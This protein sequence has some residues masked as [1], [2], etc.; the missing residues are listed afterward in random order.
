MLRRLLPVLVLVFGGVTASTQNNDATL[1]SGSRR[2]QQLDFTVSPPVRDLP[3]QARSTEPPKDKPVRRPHAGRASND[4][5]DP[6]VQTSTPTTATAQSLG[7]W[8]G[9]GGGYPGY[10]ITAVPPDPNMA[11]GPN[12]IVQ[13]VNNAFVVFD[14]QGRQVLAPVDDETFWGNSTCNQLGGF[15]DPIVQYDRLSDRWVIGEVA[16]PLFPGLIGQFAQCFAVS[17]S[18]DPTGSYYMWAY[19]FGSN[20]NDYPKISVWPDG[21]YVTWNIFSA[22]ESFLGP[23]ACAFRRSDMIS[24]VAAP[25]Y[26]CFTL[27]NGVSSLLP[28]DLDGAAMPPSGSPNFL[29]DVNASTGALH[30]WKFHADYATPRNST[31]TGLTLTGVAPFTAPCLTTQ[32]CVPQPATTQKLDALG[33]R[34]MYRL[35]YRNFGDHA[36]LVANH[37]VLTPSGNIGVR[38]YE[39]RNPAGTPTIFQQGTF[40]PDSDNRW[41]G[42]IAMDH[43][44][45]IGVGYS[46]SSAATYPSIRFT[47]WE[48]GSPL[49]QLESE[50]NAVVGTG[51]QTGYNRWGDYSAMRIDP[52]DDCTFWYTQEYQATTVDADWSTRIV[53][54]SFPAC[55]PSPATTTTL[56]SSL[57]PS[58][59]FD[60]VTFTATVS[61][62]AATGTVQFFDGATAIGGRTLSGGT[63]SLT[64]STLAVGSHSITAVYGGDATYTGS[65][66]S[67]VSQTVTKA[68]T[69]TALASSLNPSTAGSAVTFTATVSPA[70]A[71]GTVQFLDGA[72][73]LGSAAVSGGAATLSTSALTAGTHAITAVYGG[74]VRYTGSTSSP[75]SQVVN[76]APVSTTTSLTSSVNP[77]NF[78][79]AVTLTATVTPASGTSTPTGTVTFSDG[80]TTLGSAALDSSGSAALVTSTLAAGAHSIAAQYA[81]GNG[82][83]GSTSAALSQVVNVVATATSLT[84]SPNPSAFGQSVSLVAAVTPSSGTAMPTGTVTFTDG[85]T[86]I[87]SAALNPNGVATFATSSLSAGTHS[88]TAQYGG[89]G[90]HSG[91]SSTAV[92]QTVNKANTTT[93]L[94]S[95]K[96]PSTSGDSVTFTATVTPSA[97]TGTVQFL[98][99]ATSLGSAALSGGTASLSTSAL[100]AGNHSITAV[101]GG[102]GTYAG[103]TSAL[104]TQVVGNGIVATTTS[105]A[106]SPNPSTFGQSVGLVATVTQSSGTVTP[107]GTVT[108]TDGAA[109]IGSAALDSNGVATLATS[110]LSTGTHSIAAQYAGDGTHSGSSSAPVSQTV[111]RANTATAVTSN[112]NPSTFG[113]SVTFTVAMTPSAATGTVQFL[114]G[115]TSLGS[116]ALSGG[117]ASLSTSALG[118]G[119]HSITAVYAGDNSYA[120]ST[121]PAV[122]QVVNSSP[123]TTTSL[124]AS[125]NP[126]T[127]GQSVALVS[128]VT[129]SPGAATPTGAVTFVDGATVLGSAPLDS[130]G[131]A[132]LVTSSLSVGTH[133]IASQ[134]GGDGTHSG[135]ASAAVVQTVNKVDTTTTVTSNRN[136]SNGGQPITFTATVSP[137]TATGTVQFLDGGV[138]FGSAALSNGTAALTTSVLSAG[139]HTI[140]AQYGGDA[141]DNGSVSAPLT[142]IVGKKK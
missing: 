21:Y 25:L 72:T 83:N 62:S 38:W 28:S 106:S 39:V 142:Q 54:F 53:S 110:S 112:R 47:G 137:S 84:A 16:I 49:G 23:E 125:P 59:L 75:L 80:A 139:T 4:G 17:T 63:A 116:V 131:I 86:T 107:T 9:L 124:T 31:F 134:Y 98:D 140:T 76:S 141:N 133:S 81:G 52:V 69:T 15:S 123:A 11:V 34:L 82:F 51:S 42:S 7:Q 88:I 35:A 127:F 43:A 103:S 111:N 32:D 113:D 115:A 121:S 3:A 57:N 6:I 64:T 65:T 20:I 40:A 10:A 97:A 36:S 114:D 26:V 74:D 60:A 118:V 8:E 68:D 136:P 93:G 50:T 135:S 119:N 99:G 14:K 100:A 33:D 2:P 46:V 61:P 22:S 1:A 120:G 56:A 91:S 18:P 29:M 5:A 94:A 55:G 96:N 105:L 41:M 129:P 13:W 24:G 44:G 101:Y 104:V 27:A 130:N 12:H 78:G 117:A 70:G 128:T 138:V 30:L 109:T 67:A 102:D 95:S 37:S 73:T 79:D 77:S 48:V 66:S 122:T 19:G 126:S 85:A 58:K 71:T 87:G 92:S 89:D 45:N 90:N 132:T 108:F